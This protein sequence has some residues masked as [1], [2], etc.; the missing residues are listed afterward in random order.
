M[1]VF[2]PI[3]SLMTD[4]KHLV[5]VSSD[6]NLMKVKEIF[7]AH[8]FHHIPVV[9]FREI[10][11]IISRIDFEHFLGGASLYGENRIVNEEQLQNTHA[12]DIMTT[13]LGKV[14]PD[15]RINVA[16]EIFTLNRF[17]ALPV[18]K[19]GD[20]VGIITPFDI[21]RKLADEKPAQPHLVYETES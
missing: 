20:L 6:D 3:S 9:N 10:V 17:H 14:E 11:G 19:D 16:L 12:K 4:H 18:I 1:N 21:L 8:K 2:A 13:H 5:T 7:D 15:D